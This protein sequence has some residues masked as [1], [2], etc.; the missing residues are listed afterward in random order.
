MY[1]LVRSDHKAVYFEVNIKP[2]TS[3]NPKK[4]KNYSKANFPVISDTLNIFQTCA[5]LGIM[6]PMQK[7]F[8]E[9]HCNQ[10]KSS[11]E[12]VVPT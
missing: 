3:G 7:C 12:M 5:T 4:F 11:T 8:T 1:S 10:I 2:G 6:L 9:T